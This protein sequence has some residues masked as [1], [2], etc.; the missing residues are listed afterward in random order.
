MNEQTNAER[1][2][3][4][5][6]QFQ[7]MNHSA[8]DPE[9]EFS[10]RIKDL[11]L[12]YLEFNHPRR[13]Q[14]TQSVTVTHYVP[15]RR[16]MMALSQIVRAF[17]QDFRICDVGCGNGF[18]GSLLAR[19]GLNVFGID[20]RSYKQPQ[21]SSFYDRK[22][23]EILETSL[24]DPKISFD[25]AFCSWMTPG[26]NLTPEIIAKKP[27]LIIHV[28]SPDRQSNGS[29]TTGVP[30]A[31]VY[32]VRYKLIAGWVSKVPRDYFLP[33]NSNLSG[34]LRKTRVVCVYAHVDLNP[35]ARIH[36]FD[37]V[38]TYDWDIERNFIDQLR[39]SGGL[40]PWS[41]I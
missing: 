8:W 2:L 12:Y 33:L 30:E 6:L 25:G 38:G 16:E 37:F 10:V 34:N 4:N 3:Q 26:T 13:N 32:P 15:C 18:L 5:I 23:Y 19:E 11:P 31:Y 36:P 35:I 7:S 21:I 22:C 28:F 9:E 20:D 29:P 39:M 40:E 41:M 24:S 17:N 1:I 27:Y 14:A